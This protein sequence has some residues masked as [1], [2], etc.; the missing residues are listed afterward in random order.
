MWADLVFL[1]ATFLAITFLSYKHSLLTISSSEEYVFCLVLAGLTLN[2]VFFSACVFTVVYEKENHPKHTE[3][4]FLFR[5]WYDLLLFIVSVCLV[6]SSKSF[7][8][9]LFIA[10]LAPLITMEAIIWLLGVRPSIS[11]AEYLDQYFPQH[12]IRD[13]INRG[14]RDWQIQRL[15]AFYNENND[16][17][18]R[19]L[20]EEDL[21][22]SQRLRLAEISPIIRVID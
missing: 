12:L 4:F 17:S 6:V 13:S 14:E 18:D 1:A 5:I 3:E 20:L 16:G 7:N 15:L 2:K 8:T 22:E 10:T 19:E 9:G 21:E 11:K